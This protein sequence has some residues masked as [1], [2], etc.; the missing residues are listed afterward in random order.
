MRRK[1]QV[2]PRHR[3]TPDP[4]AARIGARIRSFRKEQRFSFDAFV[5]ETG[6]GRGYVSELERGLVVPTVATLTRVARALELTLADLVVG[7]TERER[8]FEDTR[9]M[10]D[11]RVRQLRAAA[12]QIRAEYVAEAERALLV[13]DV[14]RPKR[15]R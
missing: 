15:T 14:A 5:E 4:L 12:L 1:R 7:E 13:A 3:T 6:L 9:G 11:P 10:P 8:L 2:A